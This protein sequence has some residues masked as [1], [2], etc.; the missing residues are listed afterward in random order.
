M[1]GGTI[2]GNGLPVRAGVRAVVAAEATGKVIVAEIS[3]S[4]GFAR[5]SG[6]PHTLRARRDRLCG[7]LA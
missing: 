2:V 5:A 6:L 7:E 3:P 1:A 4:E